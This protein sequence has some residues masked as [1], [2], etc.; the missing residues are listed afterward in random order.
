MKI[1]QQYLAVAIAGSLGAMLRFFVATVCR[2]YLPG[3]FPVGTFIINISGSFFLGWFLA[4]FGSRLE[5]VRLAVA[6]GFV[7]A[8]TTFSTY[9][10]ESNELLTQRAQFVALIYLI[11]S[12]AAGLISVRAGI[13]LGSR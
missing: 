4:A 2:R 11:G 10:F 7:G 9:M 8:Y 1:A 5:L 6:V 3:S 12:V 13:W